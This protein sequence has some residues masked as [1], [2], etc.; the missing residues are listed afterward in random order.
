MDS[1]R[2]GMAWVQGWG[3]PGRGQGSAG[4]VMTLELHVLEANEVE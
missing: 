4:G 2:V 3:W 1:V